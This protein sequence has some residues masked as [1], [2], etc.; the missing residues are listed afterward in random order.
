MRAKVWAGKGEWGEVSGG[1]GGG[2]VVK[3][4]KNE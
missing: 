3:G 4:L 1:G 2:G